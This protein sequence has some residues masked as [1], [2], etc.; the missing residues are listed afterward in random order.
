MRENEWHKIVKYWQNYGNKT[1]GL[2]FPKT[3][4]SPYKFPTGGYWLAGYQQAI[5]DF[6]YKYCKS[7]TKKL[8]EIKK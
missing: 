8:K 7:I 2:L 3:K 6:K 5:S 4:K 1:A